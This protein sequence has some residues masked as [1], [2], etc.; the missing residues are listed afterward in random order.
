MLAKPSQASDICLPLV[1]L[2]NSNNIIYFSCFH[3]ERKRAQR[4]RKERDGREPFYLGKWER[5]SAG[6]RV[7]VFVRVGRSGCR[8]FF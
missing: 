3:K 2:R 1:V 5:V 4:V 6:E 7:R 8:K